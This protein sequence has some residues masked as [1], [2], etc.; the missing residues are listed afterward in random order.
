M[1]REVPMFDKRLKE[2]AETGM[3]EEPA[4]VSL[5]EIDAEGNWSLT[6]AGRARLRELERRLAVEDPMDDAMS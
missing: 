1:S 6:E 5:V 4:F 3:P 2:F